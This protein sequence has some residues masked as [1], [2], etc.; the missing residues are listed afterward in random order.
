M[1]KPQYEVAKKKVIKQVKRVQTG[2]STEKNNFDEVKMKRDEIIDL[3][4]HRLKT[5]AEVKLGDD[6]INKC[7]ELIKFF[8][9]PCQIMWLSM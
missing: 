8:W 3:Y 6:V 9:Q 5:L 4:A 2:M 7:K 1:R